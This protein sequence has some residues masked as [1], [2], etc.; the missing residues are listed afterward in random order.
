MI[1]FGTN[2]YTG[3]TTVNGGT[4]QVDGSIA[5]SVLTT[6]NSGA[7]L[8]GTG[9]V[10]NTIIRSGGT[11]Q[12]GNTGNP[13]GKLNFAGSL[14]LSSASIYMITINGGNNSAV[15]VSGTATLNGG[16]VLTLTNPIQTL[17]VNYPI[18]C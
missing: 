2:T 12:P 9:I 10:G 17:N 8:S 14:T 13:L 1:L 15:N 18:R 5:N 7:M 11:L 3:A 16:A 6:V 4:L